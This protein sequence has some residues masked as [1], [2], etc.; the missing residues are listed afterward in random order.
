M[1]ETS[2][3]PRTPGEHAV[4]QWARAQHGIVT[5]EQCRLAGISPRM[6]R[7][8]IAQG[9]WARRGRALVIHAF[10]VPGDRH[11]A[12][13]VQAEAGLHATVS[14]PVA[15]RLGGWQIDGT[16]RIVV[17]TEHDKSMPP[18]VRVLRRLNPAWPVPSEGLRLA[19]PIDALADTAICR[20]FTQ[21]CTL[22]D[23]ALQR[24][25]FTADEFDELIG[26]RA[27]HGRRGV[28][29]LREL[30][31][32]VISGSRSEAEQ[33]M[34]AILRRSGTGPWRGNYPMRDTEGHIA[35]EIDFADVRRRIAVEVDGRAYHT[36]EVSFE[37]DRVRQNLL[38]MQGWIVLRFTW[39]QITGD[40]KGVERTICEATSRAD[41]NI[42]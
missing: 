12:W 8:R 18:G 22:I 9:A 21:A 26:H 29:R 38:M 36:D 31:E 4:H 17:L 19:R 2:V 41:R 7:T 40:A 30:R 6:E 32:R 35:A 10:V 1:P 5:R 42:G 24:R 3:R 14:G 15:A 16:E 27:G 23:R 37:R 25:W 13:V 34:R 33:R 20:S 11:E 39:Q 28:G